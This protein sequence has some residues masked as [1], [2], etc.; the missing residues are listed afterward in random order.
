MF[1]TPYTT[2]PHTQ[3]ICVDNEIIVSLNICVQLKFKD[4]FFIFK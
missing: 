1:F 2:T 4:S 3:S